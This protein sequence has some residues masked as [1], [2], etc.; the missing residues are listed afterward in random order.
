MSTCT[1]R[2]SPLHSGQ[3]SCFEIPTG[4][5][6]AG[7]SGAVHSGQGHLSDSRRRTVRPATEYSMVRTGG[8]ISGEG[9]FDGEVRHFLLRMELFRGDADFVLLGVARHIIDHA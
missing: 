5:S 4:R 8:F 2:N 7:W 3:A 6:P 9:S 1:T